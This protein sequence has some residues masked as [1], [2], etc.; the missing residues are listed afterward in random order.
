MA[1]IEW[2]GGAKQR[3]AGAALAVIAGA[4]LGWWLNGVLTVA[5]PDSSWNRLP[6]AALIALVIGRVANLADVQFSDG[7]LV[8]AAV[9]AAVAWWVVPEADSAELP[10]LIPALATTIWL[11][12]ILLDK[13][14]NQPASGSVSAA[15]ILALLTAGGVLVFAGTKRLMDVDVILASA[16][17]GIA[18]VAWLRG[19]GINGAIPAAAVILPSLLLMGQRTT[20]AEFHW[21]VF[22]LPALAPLLLAITLPF[23]DW[24]RLRLH[25]ARIALIL[26]PLGVAGAL[27]LSS[28]SLSGESEW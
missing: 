2:L 10:W 21:C 25:A 18:L 8:R 5:G 3:S 13:L 16:I 17:A 4:G 12:W 22:L 27:V 14:T 7:W 23:K 20:F 9:S 15:V 11:L 1:G 19:F 24:P 26:I 6:W 28:A